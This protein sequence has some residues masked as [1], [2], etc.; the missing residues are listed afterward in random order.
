MTFEIDK[1]LHTLHNRIPNVGIDCMSTGGIHLYI[2]G[3]AIKMPDGKKE[4]MSVYLTKEQATLLA[5]EIFYRIF[6]SYK[7]TVDYILGI[8]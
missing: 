1:N 4:I 3:N 8:D 5:K 6:L 7:T 2:F